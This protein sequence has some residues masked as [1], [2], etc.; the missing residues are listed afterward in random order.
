MGLRMGKREKGMAM[1]MRRQL[2]R[3]KMGQN[4]K[5]RIEL[6]RENSKRKFRKNSEKKMYYFKTRERRKQVSP[7]STCVACFEILSNEARSCD[8]RC[9]LTRHRV[10][11]SELIENHCILLKNYTTR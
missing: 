8:K 4:Y 10:R 11:H 2:N 1:G 3:S 9:K 7:S 6:A 5:S